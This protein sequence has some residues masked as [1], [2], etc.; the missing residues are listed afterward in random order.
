MTNTTG[1]TGGPLKD[2]ITEFSA[3]V[4][5][6]LQVHTELYLRDPEQA[7]YWNP[8]VVGVD[9]NPFRCLLLEHRGRKSG[10]VYHAV[11]QCFDFDGKIVIVGSRG[12]NVA[13]ADWYLNLVANPECGVRI[14]SACYRAR[15][16]ITT[17]TERARL[18]DLI[19]REQPLQLQ[20]Q[21]VTS[22]LIP[23][24]ALELSK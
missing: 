9:G 10:K 3:H 22:R 17:G 21:A 19:T 8:R 24:I 4:Q 23:V 16:R 20:Y 12:G 7:L 5:R 11:L 13:H 6:E 1:D 2:Q 15:A 18:W 14:G